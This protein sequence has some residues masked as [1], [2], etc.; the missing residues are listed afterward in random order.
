MRI[1]AIPS[2]ALF[3]SLLAAA[4]CTKK[5]EPAASAAAPAAAPVVPLET[6]PVPPIVERAADS[7]KPGEFLWKPEASPSGPVLIVVS[8]PEQ[9]AHV[10]RNGIAIGITTVS[11]GRKGHPTPTGV[12]TILE[13]D[14]RHFSK[15][16]N[17]A[18][19]PFMER[20]TWD[21]IALHAGNLPGYPA[22][23]GCVRMPKEF[24]RLL[25]GVTQKGLTVV[26]A[27]D[28]HSAQALVHPGL[29]APVSPDAKA[30]QDLALN[31]KDVF[32]WEPEKA[33]AG[34]VS[35]LISS[36]DSALYA[37]R[38]GVEIGRAKLALDDP[39]TPLGFA[40]YNMLEGYEQSP[41]PIAPDLRAHRWMRVHFKKDG[42]PATTS[43]I[44][45]RVRIPGEFAKSLYASLE[46]GSTLQVTDLPVS[47]QPRTTPGFVVLSEHGSDSGS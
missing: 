16:Y 6:K 13:K 30:A 10:Y 45:A 46:P 28:E 27:D 12:F 31:G 20:L 42:V 41:S 24:A 44:A 26:I 21:G 9:R 8:I 7:L 17:N 2:I 32:T 19:M 43:T 39:A 22:S 35:I 1:Q 33:G 15:T 47:G 38:Q 40:V 11:T 25:F 3:L 29:L 5:T 23:H 18:P 34:P 14:E 37:Y 4:G 36:A